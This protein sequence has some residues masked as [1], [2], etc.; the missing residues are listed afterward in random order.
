MAK[1][2]KTNKTRQ[3]NVKSEPLKYIAYQAQVR[4]KPEYGSD[5]VLPNAQILIQEDTRYKI[6]QVECVQRRATRWI[7]T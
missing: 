5:I 1:R 7:K 6:Y 2:V 3:V 4:P